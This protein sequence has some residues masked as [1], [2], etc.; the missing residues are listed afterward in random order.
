MP[1]VI[2]G[3][4][5]CFLECSAWSWV[6]KKLYRLIGERLVEL[7]FGVFCIQKNLS[8]EAKID[9]GQSNHEKAMPILKALL[10]NDDKGLCYRIL[11]K[12]AKDIHCWI[13]YY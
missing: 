8:F 12:M 11:Q 2:N 10:E 6:T 9:P 13:C 7:N 5:Y 4:N 1:N 3:R